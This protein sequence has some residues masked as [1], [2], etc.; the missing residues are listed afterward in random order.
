MKLWR[1][2]ARGGAAKGKS[3][4]CRLAPWIATWSGQSPSAICSTWSK[5]ISRTRID[6][7]LFSASDFAEPEALSRTRQ[8]LSD[9][10]NSK[11]S[12]SSG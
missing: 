4:P 10:R 11:R 5:A 9:W 6:L 2:V 3:R 1:I 12:A 7:T 8:S